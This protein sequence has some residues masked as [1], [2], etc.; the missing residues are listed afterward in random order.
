MRTQKWIDRALFLS[1]AMHTCT[2]TRAL[3]VIT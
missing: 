2:R 3:C 1:R